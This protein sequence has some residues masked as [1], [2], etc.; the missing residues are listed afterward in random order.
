VADVDERGKKQAFT[1]KIQA[2]INSLLLI[3]SFSFIIETLNCYQ[4]NSGNTI[5]I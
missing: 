4:F 3:H 1:D 5:D 2:S